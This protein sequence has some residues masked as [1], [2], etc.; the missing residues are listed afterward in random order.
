MIY[1]D[2]Y[3]QTQTIIDNR[4]KFMKEYNIIKEGY[5]YYY[6]FNKPKYKGNNLYHFRSYSMSNN[7]NI[8]VVSL[9]DVEKEKEWINKEWIGNDWIKIY[10]IYNE[11]TTTFIKMIDNQLFIDDINRRNK[12]WERI[13]DER[14]LEYRIDDNFLC[15]ECNQ[16]IGW[17]Q[18]TLGA[19][20]AIGCDTHVYKYMNNEEDRGGRI[21][22]CNKCI[23]KTLY[24]R[25]LIQIWN[26]EGKLVSDSYK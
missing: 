5:D 6:D 26:E 9:Y 21:W 1:E 14:Y 4:N 15:H 12:K 23:L 10:P 20:I 17:Y 18:F 19:K 2:V 24:N 22:A 13:P 7:K 8:Y 11:D 16:Y 25:K 3:C